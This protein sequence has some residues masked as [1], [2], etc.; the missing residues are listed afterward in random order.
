MEISKFSKVRKIILIAGIVIGLVD[1][2]IIFPFEYSRSSYITDFVLTDIC[3]V[4]AVFFILYGFTGSGFL[5]YLLGII[6]SA[7]V[8]AACWAL[9][10][11]GN[12]LQKFIVVWLGIPSGI[13]TALV[14]F[15]LRYY[16]FCRNKTLPSERGKKIRTYLL[17]TVLYFV[18]LLIISVLFYTGGEWD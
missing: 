17:Q 10:L 2:C 14:F 18:L 11:D 13:L 15:V 5:K 8:S 12:W 4:V 7:L 16:I 9:F 1:L 3:L 6:V